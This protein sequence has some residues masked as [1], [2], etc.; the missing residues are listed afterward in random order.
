MAGRAVR[1]MCA[2]V[3]A[4][5]RE[6]VGFCIAGGGTC[7]A[8]RKS[9]KRPA[10]SPTKSAPSPPSPACL[11]SGSTPTGAREYHGRTTPSRAVS[12]ERTARCDSVR[13]RAA[14]GRAQLVAMPHGS[15]ARALRV[16]C[17]AAH[18]AWPM[19]KSA[20]GGCFSGTGPSGTGLS[21][22]GL[23]GSD[24]KWQWAKSAWAKWDWASVGMSL[25]GVADR[26]WR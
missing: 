1:R 18:R 19:T 4:C 9:F 21:R 5:V 23:S 15:I 6:G 13:F 24:A 2:C 14:G 8:S 3:R 10:S 20:P 26:A 16:A 12:V 25:R 7:P 11:S 17:R 22:H